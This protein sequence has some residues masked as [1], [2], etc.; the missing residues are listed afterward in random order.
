MRLVQVPGVIGSTLRARRVAGACELEG[1]FYGCLATRF[2]GWAIAMFG[3]DTSAS[4]GWRIC[5]AAILVRA[6]DLCESKV[7]SILFWSV[8]VEK[9]RRDD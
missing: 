6:R 1:R 8:D 5:V 3:R 7:V 4:A 9:K 2:V